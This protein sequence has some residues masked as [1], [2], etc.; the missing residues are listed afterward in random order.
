[1]KKL[2][3]GLLRRPAGN[4]AKPAGGAMKKKEAIDQAY[5]DVSPGIVTQIFDRVRMIKR[6]HPDLARRIDMLESEIRDR[7][8]LISEAIGQFPKVEREL[9]TV[10][11]INGIHKMC[12]EILIDP[13]FDTHETAE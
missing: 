5:S 3:S 10:L 12:D 6:K 11:V 7:L 1:L 2:L 8:M 4:A 9:V 13:D